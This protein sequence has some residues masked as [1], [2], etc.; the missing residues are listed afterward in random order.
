MMPSRHTKQLLVPLN[1]K[2]CFARCSN[3]Q[4]NEMPFAPRM[5]S[6]HWGEYDPAKP[7]VEALRP[8]EIKQLT[9]LQQTI[10]VEGPKLFQPPDPQQPPE[11]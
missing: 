1:A 6:Q 7:H 3:W 8:E 2:I 10:V 5:A 9:K 4:V 11:G